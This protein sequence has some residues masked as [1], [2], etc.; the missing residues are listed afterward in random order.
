MRES[1]QDRQI[2]VYSYIFIYES[3]SKKLHYPVLILRNFE[4]LAPKHW[5]FWGCEGAQ[6]LFAPLR[7]Y[8]APPK[9]FL[10]P[11]AKVQVIGITSLSTKTETECYSKQ[12]YLHP[13]Q[14]FFSLTKQTMTLQNS[15]LYHK[16]IT[17]D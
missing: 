6:N 8:L 9:M 2:C 15:I 7:R 16:F 11:S 1:T 13:P 17:N 4:K 5:S 12:Y 10:H 14:I 3:L